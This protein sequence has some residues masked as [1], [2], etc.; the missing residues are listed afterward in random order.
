[1]DI[2]LVAGLW[3][4]NSIWD[5]TA[6]ELELGGHRVSTPALP[7]VDDG[8][9]TATLD[10]QVAAVVAAIDDADRPLL[11]GHS[12]ACALVWMAADRRAAD[13]AGVAMIGGFP[14]ADGE[15]YADFFPMVDGAMPFPGWEPFEGPDADD[16]DPAARAAIEA[17]A[18]PV[19]EKVARGTVKLSAPARHGLAVVLVCPEYSPDDALAWIESGDLPE[20][21][22]TDNVLTVDIDSGHWPMVSRPVELA[23]LLD[24]ATVAIAPQP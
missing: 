11:V 1:M 18:V 8:S 24:A 9:T 21:D 6:A 14:S 5:L 12:A 10:D 17:V 2:L 4:P 23:H 22:A 7:G 3:L 16:L 13:V 15:V 19:P 20:L